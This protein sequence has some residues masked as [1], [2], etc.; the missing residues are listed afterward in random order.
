MK[1]LCVYKPSK[2]EGTP[3]S[4]DEMAR[5]TAFI[6]QSFKSGVLIATEGC[7]PSALGARVRLSSGKITVTDGPFTEAK[8]LIGGFALIQA[9]SEEH[10]IDELIAKELLPGYHLLP[11]VRGDLRSKPGRREEA[12]AEFARAAALARNT[13]ERDLLLD[14]AADGRDAFTP[15]QPN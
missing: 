5:M 3:P 11:S 1:F 14:R 13:R 15:P 6:Q 10:A 4:Q 9:G 12:Q 2:P 8:E 7:L